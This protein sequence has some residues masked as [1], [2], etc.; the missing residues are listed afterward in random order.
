MSRERYSIVEYLPGES[1][2]SCGYCRSKSSSYSNWIWAKIMTVDDYQALIDRSWRRCGVYCYKPIMTTTCCPMYTIKC[3]VKDFRVSKSQKKILKRF[4]NFLAYGVE[5]KNIKRSLLNKT[6]FVQSVDL[7]EHIS[8]EDSKTNSFEAAQLKFDTVDSNKISQLKS[9]DLKKVEIA[10]KVSKMEVPASVQSKGGKSHQM[11]AK[12]LRIERKKQKLRNQGLSEKE[13]EERMLAKKKKCIIKT[14]EDYLNETQPKNPAHKLEIKLVRSRSRGYEAET[15]ELYKRYQISVHNDPPEKLSFQSFYRFLVDS[16][17]EPEQFYGSYHQQYWLDG[18]LIAVGVVDILPKCV[19][20]VYFLY[21]PEYLWLSLGTYGALRE[22]EF[23]RK[24]TSQHPS[25]EYYYMGYYIHSCVKMKYKAAFRPSYLLC[26]EVYTWHPIQSCLP[27]LDK[28]KYSRLNEDP[29]A[30]DE[31]AS[32]A[33]GE[34]SVVYNNYV[35]PFSG[36][37]KLAKCR[38]EEIR[39]VEK[40]ASLV[41]S[42]CAG[43]MY[44]DRP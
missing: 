8:K 21:D 6:E 4:H 27:K 15:F 42:V 22:I 36:Y 3:A 11:K 37:C 28:S 43:R 13:I 29:S 12:Y 20:S 23:V 35:M 44:L 7:P 18:K 38:Q 19:S 25:I 33:V 16:P 39:N 34:V 26:P 17:L 1:G 14:L 5:N 9:D 31:N 30:K 10:N 24:L 41:G 40:Y 32:I 2:H